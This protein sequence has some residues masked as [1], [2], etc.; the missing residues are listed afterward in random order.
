MRP[1]GRGNNALR[2]EVIEVARLPRPSAPYSHVVRAGNFLFVAGQVGINPAKGKLKGNSTGEQTE[3]A[4]SNMVTILEAAG[5]SM[6]NVVKTTVFLSDFRDFQ[7]MNGAYEKFFP[8]KQP[9]RS[10]V[11]VVLYDGFKVEI[12]AI[13]VVP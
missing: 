1:I 11:Q 8:N 3:Q 7:E 12:E 9:A 6:D 5:S 2:K 13:A 4:L 10:A